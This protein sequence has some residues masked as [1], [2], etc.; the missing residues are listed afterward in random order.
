M[1]RARTIDAETEAPPEADRLGEWPHPR[2]TRHVLG[3]DAAEHI[4]ADAIASR[5]L[6]H[7]WLLTGEQGIGKASFAYRVARYLLA[8]EGELPASVPSLDVPEDSRA[9]RQVANLSHPG[10]LPI[11]RAWDS[12][13]KKFRQSIAIDDIRAL[14]HFLQRTAV[15]PWRVVIVDAADDLNPNS[16]NALLKSLEEPP[17]RAVFLLI[18]S[19]PGRLLPTIRSR[20][21]TIRFE[22][23]G[24]DPLRR[25]VLAASE[26]AEH[27]PPADAQ[28]A[29]LLTLGKGSPRRVLQ[30][31]D[32][33][34]LALFEAIIAILDSV[35]RLD[36]PA[37][38]KLI[39]LT[40]ARDGN[41]YAMA[42]DLIEEILASSMRARAIGESHDPQFPQLRRFPAQIAPDSLAEWA[43]LWETIREARS[44]AERLNL[45]KAALTL[46]VFEQIQHLARKAARG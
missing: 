33:G 40:A 27:D 7:A 38:H 36:R 44:E 42:F 37:V 25:A 6:H 17:P 13:G 19:S 43:E 8:H 1:A 9:W 10:L 14:R 11:R 16:A 21:R 24:P 46:T 5:R 31:L 22:P 2:N 23:L 12:A 28:L 35:P 41:A 4:I 18:S 32:G 15:T 45:D 20:C 29:T 30:L 3:H 34:G 26:A 39:G